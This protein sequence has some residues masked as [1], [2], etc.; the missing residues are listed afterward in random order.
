MNTTQAIN[1]I[2]QMTPPKDCILATIDVKSLYTNIPQR[3]GT[4]RVLQ[5]YYNTPLPPLSSACA[6]L[7]YLTANYKFC[8][9]A[10]IIYISALPV[11]Y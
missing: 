7:D 2:E 8:M 5:R 6:M 1:I 9:H 11:V 10:T 4:E 3:Q